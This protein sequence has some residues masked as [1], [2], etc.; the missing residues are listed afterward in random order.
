MLF[1]LFPPQLLH[2]RNNEANQH[3]HARGA[4]EGR[5]QLNVVEIIHR[6]AKLG[7]NDTLKA[8]ESCFFVVVFLLLLH[9]KLFIVME[10]TENYELTRYKTHMKHLS[11]RLMIWGICTYRVFSIEYNITVSTFA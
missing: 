9:I 10:T 5:F 8:E 7:G 6:T 4:I 2:V 3:P 11:Q 1:F